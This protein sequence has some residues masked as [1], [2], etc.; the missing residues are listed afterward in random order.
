MFQG[1]KYLILVVSSSFKKQTLSRA[2]E[3]C[4]RYRF[5]MNVREAAETARQNYGSNQCIHKLLY[6]KVLK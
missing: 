5:K 6:N 4:G 1:H 2:I 3:P